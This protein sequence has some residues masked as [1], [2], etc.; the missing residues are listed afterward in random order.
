MQLTLTTKNKQKKQDKQKKTNVLQHICKSC[1]SSSNLPGHRDTQTF[2]YYMDAQLVILWGREGLYSF[3]FPRGSEFQAAVGP[4]PAASSVWKGLEG[5]TRALADTE[6]SAWVWLCLLGGTLKIVG[7]FMG[8]CAYEK[9]KKKSCQ[10]LLGAHLCFLRFYIH[11]LCVN[12]VPLL[13][14]DAD[15]SNLSMSLQSQCP[16]EGALAV[17]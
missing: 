16:I 11:L 7:V 15:T 6:L 10:A 9:K 8:T 12:M 5:Q 13:S 1:W 14:W 3:E 4:C 2:T 17:C